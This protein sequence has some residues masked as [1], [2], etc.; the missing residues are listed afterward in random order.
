MK[1]SSKINN[2]DVATRTK[3]NSII[4]EAIASVKSQSSLNANFSKINE[5]KLSSLKNNKNLTKFDI[6][7]LVKLN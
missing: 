7:S 2:I 1:N 4:D 5:A 6:E 3:F